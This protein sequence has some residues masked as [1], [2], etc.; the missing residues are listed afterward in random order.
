MARFSGA[1]RMKP[2]A[3]RLRE[4][5]PVPT[6]LYTEYETLIWL[7]YLDRH[8]PSVMH[9]PYPCRHESLS[10]LGRMGTCKSPPLA[11]GLVACHVIGYR[12]A[13]ERSIEEQTRPITDRVKGHCESRHRIRITNGAFAISFDGT[14]RTSGMNI[15]DVAWSI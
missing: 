12:C 5:E 9:S 8:M 3:N 6:C 14:L 4:M 7:A 10:N 13:F 15:R 2:F 1:L 11:S